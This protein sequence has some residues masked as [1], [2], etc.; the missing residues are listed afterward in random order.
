M[1]HPLVTTASAVLLALSAAAMPAF[2]M[3]PSKGEGAKEG[4]KTGSMS[5]DKDSMKKD[6]MSKDSMSK[7]KN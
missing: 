6:S 4:A 1:R 3:E 7:D 2:A 5:K